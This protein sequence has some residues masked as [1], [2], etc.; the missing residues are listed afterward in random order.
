MKLFKI[1]VNE[2][3]A[4]LTLVE[5]RPRLI[6]IYS[7]NKHVVFVTISPNPKKKY[8]I[9]RDGSKTNKRI[10]V[11]YQNMTHDEQYEYI[12]EYIRDVYAR[13]MEHTDWMYII[14]EV[15]QDNNMHA[16]ML[17]YSDSIQ[18][19]YDIKALQKTVYS[20]IKT[21][22]NRVQNKDYMNNIVYLDKDKIDYIIDYFTK[23]KNIK[24]K[25]PDEYIEK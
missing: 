23:D 3:L 6:D 2:E 16:H 15:N 9:I 20:N 14:Y 1:V 10:S 8:K 19:D 4:K 13:L 18:D 11:S 12:R 22:Y 21:V 17:L 7:R 5:F 24:K 25:F